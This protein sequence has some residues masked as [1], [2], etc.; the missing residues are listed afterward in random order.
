MRVATSQLYS[1]SLSRILELQARERETTNQISGGKRITRP[2]DDP[3]AATEVMQIRNRT[4]A[5]AQYDRNGGQ[6][7]SRL[8]QVDDVLGGVSNMLQ[9]V[10]DLVLQGRSETQGK[11]D[12]AAIAKEIREQTEV[13]LDLGNTRN[14]SGEYI[15]AGATVGTRPFTADSLGNV[16][17][18][19]DQTVRELQLSETRTI[20]ESFT[21]HDALFAVRNGNG[22]FVSGRVAGNTGTAQISDNTVKDGSSYL[23]H[24]FRVSFTSA[25]TYDIIDDTL[26]SNVA[27]AQTYVDGAA[28]TF[29]GAEIT[30]FGAPN[31]GDQFTIKP[32]LNQ[33]MFKT[34]GTIAA[35]LESGY[36]N[37]TEQA[38]FGFD[39]DRSLE[40]LDRSLEK[41]GELRST[42]GAR[43]NSVSAQADVNDKIK[44][45]METLRSKLEDVD[46]AKAITQLT[47]DTTALQ[48]AQK[49]FV[50]VQGLSLFDYL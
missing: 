33:S 14:A 10:H 1:Q 39:I 38:N 37:V 17:Y 11:S 3:V 45:N 29:N 15:F 20:A 50:K 5:A 23:A 46:L 13:L 28:I 19:G 32:S 42:T 24:D 18:N 25:T 16:S 43:L 26:G 36:T 27:T 6:A 7:E 34:L 31:G 40:A 21:G 35:V 47:Q 12:R 2:G 44:L 8:T 9:R 49:A 41:V 4:N 30:L 48:A 22:T